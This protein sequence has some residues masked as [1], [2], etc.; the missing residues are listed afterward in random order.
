[1]NIFAA[2][3]DYMSWASLLGVKPGDAPLTWMFDQNVIYLGAQPFELKI[4]VSGKTVF[5][6]LG[7]ATITSADRDAQ[8]TYSWG[9]KFFTIYD[10]NGK[11]RI[12][13]ERLSAYNNSTGGYRWKT[14]NPDTG[15]VIT[16]G[17]IWLGAAWENWKDIYFEVTTTAVKFYISGQLINTLDISSLGITGFAQ[18]GFGQQVNSSSNLG[19]STARPRFLYLVV[20]D[21]IDYSLKAYPYKPKALDSSNQFT[22]TIDMLNSWLPDR[23][24]M[25]SSAEYNV[26]CA[27]NLSVPTSGYY[28]SSPSPDLTVEKILQMDQYIGARYVQSGGVAANYRVHNTVDGGPDDYVFSWPANEDDTKSIFRKVPSTKTGTD[29]PDPASGLVEIYL[30]A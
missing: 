13:L 19:M 15:A 8:F 29:L 25:S 20:S 1:M 28:Y 2:A 9:D 16:T 11:L 5:V 21:T 24:F 3:A 14:W 27:F 22:G 17:N 12:S 18:I 6:K 26:K 4:P 10:S 23:S 7:L 30:E